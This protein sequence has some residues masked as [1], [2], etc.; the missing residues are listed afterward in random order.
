MLTQR[1]SETSLQLWQD[2]SKEIIFINITHSKAAIQTSIFHLLF[3]RTRLC[4]Y[5]I[6]LWTNT[7]D[8]DCCW[9]LQAV[10]EIQGDKHTILEH[11]LSDCF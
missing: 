2:F 7:N 6:P 4:M 3:L 8:E 9:S 1:K 11:N 10:Y 5:Y